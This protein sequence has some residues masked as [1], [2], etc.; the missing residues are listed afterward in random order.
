MANGDNAP[1]EKEYSDPYVMAN[2][3]IN[4][5]TFDTH[6]WVEKN[7]FSDEGSDLIEWDER[8]L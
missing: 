4:G 1:D 3:E 7:L 8:V 6:T 5:W 2:L